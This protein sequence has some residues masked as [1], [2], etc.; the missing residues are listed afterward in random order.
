MSTGDGGS[1]KGRAADT[2]DSDDGGFPYT[3]I[4]PHYGSYI[5]IPVSPCPVS[6]EKFTKS[7]VIRCHRRGEV[8]EIRCHPRHP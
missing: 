6:G 3:P 7:R 8:G 2:A 1:R 5:G 4:K